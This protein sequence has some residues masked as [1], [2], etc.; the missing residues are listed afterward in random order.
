MNIIVY[1]INNVFIYGNTGY[2]NI[3]GNTGYINIYGNTGYIN[4]S[5]KL[6]CEFEI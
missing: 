2:I 1:N 6:K 5:I 3:Y 4:I